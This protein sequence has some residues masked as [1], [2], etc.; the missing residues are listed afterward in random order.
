MKRD[1]TEEITRAAIV[2]RELRY[3]EKLMTHKDKELHRPKRNK[4]KK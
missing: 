2:P 4:K 1:I 3:I